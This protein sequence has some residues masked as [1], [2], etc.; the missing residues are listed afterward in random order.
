M[1]WLTT[2]TVISIICTTAVKKPTTSGS[3]EPGKGKNPSRS[4]YWLTGGV[5]EGFDSQDLK[6]GN[7]A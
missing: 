7:R 1:E 6:P 5:I 2:L 3:F 4:F